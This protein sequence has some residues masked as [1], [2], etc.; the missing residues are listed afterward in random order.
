MQCYKNHGSECK[1]QTIEQSQQ[2]TSSG[3]DPTYLLEIP[4]DFILPPETLEKLEESSELKKLLENPHLRDFLKFVHETYNPS[5][6]VKFAMKE[7]LFVEFADACLKAIHPED[8]VT[9]QEITDEQIVEKISE[10][11]EEN[12]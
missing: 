5:G 6:F 2:S 1:E 11:I 12:A 9:N 7:P 3:L 10:A 4:E 8:Y